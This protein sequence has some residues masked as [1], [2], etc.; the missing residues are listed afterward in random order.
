[1]K[2]FNGLYGRFAVGI[3]QECSALAG[4]IRI[5]NHVDLSNLTKRGKEFSH[6]VLTGLSREHT[7][8]EFVFGNRRLGRLNLSRS[9]STG[10]GVLSMQGFLRLFGVFGRPVG[11][12]G[13]PS[14]QLGMFVTND[15]DVFERSKRVKGREDVFFV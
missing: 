12:K 15:R 10:E 11:D 14:M 6:F 4:P 8:K 3:S 13:A 1:M 5:S 7:N 2:A 9:T